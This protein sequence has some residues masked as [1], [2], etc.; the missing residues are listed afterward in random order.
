RL[1]HLT[2][3]AEYSRGRFFGPVAKKLWLAAEAKRAGAR[4]GRDSSYLPVRA[5]HAQSLAWP[6]RS[7]GYPSRSP[8]IGARYRRT[9][10]STPATHSDVV[11]AVGAAGQAVEAAAQAM[12]RAEQAKEALGVDTGEPE[13][14]G[15]DPD[16][17]NPREYGSA[18]PSNKGFFDSIANEL[19]ELVDEA[20]RVAEREVAQAGHGPPGHTSGGLFGSETMEGDTP[21]RRPIINSTAEC[22]MEPRWEEARKEAERTALEAARLVKAAQTAA[23]ELKAVE[24]VEAAEAQDSEED[25]GEDGIDGDDGAYGPTEHVSR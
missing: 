19:R 3:S 24:E 4:P 20:K 23:F 25:E 16:D 6:A 15:D 1:L 17:I 12:E 21:A 2:R 7:P 5:R 22:L 18:E 11:E 13:R 14:K 10:A 9:A 8:A